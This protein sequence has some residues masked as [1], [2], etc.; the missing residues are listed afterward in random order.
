MQ[1]RR[2]EMT[3]KG[4]SRQWT[5]WIAA[6]HSARVQ[7]EENQSPPLGEKQSLGFSRTAESKGRRISHPPP[8]GESVARFLENGRVQGEENQSLGFSRT[9]ESK[10]R[11]ISHPPL[12]RSSRSVSRERP[13][14]RGG[15]SVTPPLG[16]SSRSVSRE[17]PSPRGG[18]SVTPPWGESVARFLEN[19]QQR[20]ISHP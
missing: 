1:G 6:I 9:A 14:P 17:R 5:W 3:R 15:E 2:W 13:S 18:E 11:R 10:G 8:W 7:G 19:G 4:R 12:G 20:K 16:R